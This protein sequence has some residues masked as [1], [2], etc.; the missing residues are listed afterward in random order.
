MNSFGDKDLVQ[1][2]YLQV[3]IILNFFTNDLV[4]GVAK[5]KYMVFRM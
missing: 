4:K 1:F 3:I 5:I 2:G